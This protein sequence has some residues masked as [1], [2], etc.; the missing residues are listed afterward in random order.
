LRDKFSEGRARFKQQAN[1]IVFEYD[2]RQI[3]SSIFFYRDANFR[4]DWKSICSEGAA[5]LFFSEEFD[6]SSSKYEFFAQFRSNPSDPDSQTR[7]AIAAT[8]ITEKAEESW[9]W[10]RPKRMNRKFAWDQ[11]QTRMY[12]GK[13]DVHRKKDALNSWVVQGWTE[14]APLIPENSTEVRQVESYRMSAT[15]GS[16]KTG[17]ITISSRHW[18]RGRVDAPI[19]P[20]DSPYDA[21]RRNARKMGSLKKRDIW[22]NWG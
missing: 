9:F 2:V 19:R 1:D 11:I 12:Q 5:G 15:S 16:G 22:K 17:P 13:I 20:E 8:S 7:L 4:F 10:Q 21:S 18:D 6:K 14:M 3:Q